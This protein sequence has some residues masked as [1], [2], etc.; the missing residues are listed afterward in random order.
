MNACGFSPTRVYGFCTTRNLQ[1]FTEDRT[2]VTKKRE[3][4]L[5][6]IHPEWE[7][8]V[9]ADPREKRS[10]G[11][12]FYVVS[13]QEATQLR[14]DCRYPGDSIRAH[15]QSRLLPANLVLIEEEDFKCLCAIDYITVTKQIFDPKPPCKHV[16]PRRQSVIR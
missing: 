7:W 1:K 3:R 11:I 12:M 5:L 13:I 6:K 4:G 14:L 9:I 2:P 16:E 8:L 10:D 15:I